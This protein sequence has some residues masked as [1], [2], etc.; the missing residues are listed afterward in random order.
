MDGFFVAKFKKFSNKIPVIKGLQNTADE[1]E[2]KE[3]KEVKEK[4]S[5]T[6]SS[7]SSSSSFGLKKGDV[8]EE[9]ITFD[10][11][12]DAKYMQGM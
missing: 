3:E 9:M 12:E 8:S 6:S 1:E 5:S 10:D 4:Q 2:V 11:E 7:S